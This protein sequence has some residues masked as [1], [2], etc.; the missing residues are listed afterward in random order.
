[1][2]HIDKFPTKEKLYIERQSYNCNMDLSILIYC[3]NL[4]TRL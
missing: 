1:L 3:I 4:K 2:I